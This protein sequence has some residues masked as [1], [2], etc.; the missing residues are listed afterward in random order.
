MRL[1]SRAFG[2][3]SGTVAGLLFTLC[4]SA[5]AIAPDW[6]TSVASALIHMDLRGMARGITWGSFFW[7]LLAWTIGTGLVFAAVGGF[8]NRFIGASAA[9]VRVEIP[10]HRTA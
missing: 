10:A 6:T 4:A 1:D 9:S 8:Y 2:L 3:A 7:G 5:I